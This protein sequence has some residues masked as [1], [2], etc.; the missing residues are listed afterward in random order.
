MFSFLLL[1]LYICSAILLKIQ[2]LLFVLYDKLFSHFRASSPGTEPI[3]SCMIDDISLVDVEQFEERR[4]A[5]VRRKVSRVDSL[6]KFLFSSKLEEKKSKLAE[7]VPYYPR[8]LVANV[9]P[10][11]KASCLEVHDRWL[12]VHHV[13][14]C[15]KEEEEEDNVSCMVNIN[16]DMRAPS[17]LDSRLDMDIRSPDD[18]IRSPVDSSSSVMMNNNTPSVDQK[19]RFYQR[20]EKI[21]SHDKTVHE[22][23][24]RRTARESS[25]EEK[26]CNQGR[27][28]N[29]LRPKKLSR[30][31]S[32]PSHNVRMKVLHNNSRPSQPSPTQSKQQY[33]VGS[34]STYKMS[35]KNAS[36]PVLF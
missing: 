17:E 28:D 19:S 23:G 18:S 36:K 13:Q 34:Q 26:I 32:Q 14:N 24:L 3:K 12:G 20:A 22:I 21:D 10:S 15:V 29:V 4:L 35:H 7:H 2:I 33:M 1:V 9:E 8:P 30:S 31:V 5:K 16:M 6:K 11:Y 27:V 25:D